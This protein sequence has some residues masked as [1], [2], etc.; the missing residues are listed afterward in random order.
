MAIPTPEVQMPELTLTLPGANDRSSLD[1]GSIFF[2]GTATTLIRYGGMTILTDPNFLHAGDHVHLGYGMFAKRLTDPAMEIDDLPPL[3]LCLLSHFHGD[4]W[5]RVATARLRKDL[6][7]VTTV[8]GARRLRA[9]GFRSARGL[10][11]WE[12]ARVLKGQVV[13]RVTAAPG[14]HGPSLM[15]RLLPPVMGS[16]LDWQHGGISVFRMYISGDTLVFDDL[17]RIPERFPDIDLM[18]IHLGG[19]RLF[20]VLLTMDADQGIRAIR[21]IAPKTVVPIHYDDYT[22]FKSPLEDF[23]RAVERAKLDCDVEY[24]ARGETYELGPVVRRA[25]ATRPPSA[26][27][28]TA[29]VDHAR[30]ASEQPPATQQRR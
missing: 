22:V 30:A 10:R 6:P 8:H 15:S 29:D 14:R 4:H 25:S 28:R 3:D 2:V 26:T 24:L 5:D 20:G 21:I 17:H 12:G 16:V 23:V 27:G 19:T 13:M 7:I 1:R 9:K 18:L 11:T